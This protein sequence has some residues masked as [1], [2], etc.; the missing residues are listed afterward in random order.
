MGATGRNFAAGLPTGPEPFFPEKGESDL[1][2]A[3][4]RVCATCPVTAECL[5]FAFLVGADFGIF[6]GTTAEERR[7]LLRDQRAA[8]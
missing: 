6:G 4:E 2:R 5:N 8:A 3:A 1:A 7:T